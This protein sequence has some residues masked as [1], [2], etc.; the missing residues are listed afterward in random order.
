VERVLGYTAKV[1]AER[2]RVARAF[3]ELPA[4]RDSVRRGELSW[5][6]AREVSRVAVAET[7][8][9]WIETCR[10]ERV[11]D[12]ERREDPATGQRIRRT[13]RSGRTS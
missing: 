4:L 7:V 8:H 2:I 5:S 11:R 3:A 6:A 12:V 1:G 10:D 9:E 13:R